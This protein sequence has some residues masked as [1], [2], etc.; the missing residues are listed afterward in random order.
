MRWRLTLAGAGFVADSGYRCSSCHADIAT[1]MSTKLLLFLLG[2]LS[3]LGAIVP[4]SIAGKVYRSAGFSIADGASSFA[5]ETIVFGQD[6][7]FIFL[8]FA[9]FNSTK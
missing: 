8:S 5:E 7:R 2:S 6:G 9:K 4:D 1:P 3:C